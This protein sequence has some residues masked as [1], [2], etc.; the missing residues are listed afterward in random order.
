M[1]SFNLSTTD[2]N[3]STRMEL[4][5]LGIWDGEKFVLVTREEDGW[6]EKL[7][8]VWRYG[9]APF[10]TNR[11]MKEAVGK[12]LNMYE[13]PVFPWRSLSDA[14]ERVGLLE[15]T[16]VTGEQYLEANGL[17]GRFAK[18]VVQARYVS[19]LWCG[20]SKEKRKRKKGLTRTTAHA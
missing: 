17:M 7:K 16:G 9:T 11:L 12:F 10:W 4:P 14:V 19:V 3:I 15:T 5:D 6:W 2:E 1:K 13:E 20:V 8:L 18:E